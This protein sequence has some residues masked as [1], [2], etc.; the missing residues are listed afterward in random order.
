MKV[1]LAT[2]NQG[3]VKEF[4]ELLAEL[5]I[6]IMGL[7][8]FPQIGD[9]E[10]TGLTFS[11]NAA[12]KAEIVTFS[13]GLPTVADDSGLEVDALGGAPGVNSARFAGVH[14]DDRANNEKL[15]E[16]MSGVTELRTGRFRCAIAICVP[17]G[18]DTEAVTKIIKTHIVEGSCEG[19][20][21]WKA[22]G[23]HGFGYDPLFIPDGYEI[24]M[25]QMD[26]VEKNKISHRAKAVAKA[27][28]ILKELESDH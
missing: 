18:K 6:E 8:Q 22:V 14:G 26:D 19:K 17:A 1:V 16:L 12:L 7:D 27:I 20:I 15:L 11:E 3:K 28:D 4:R 9:I 2:R 13:T 25:G 5:D 24:T 23:Q 21:G 10:E